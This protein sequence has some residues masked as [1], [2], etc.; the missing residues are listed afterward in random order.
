MCAACAPVVMGLVTLGGGKCVSLALAL[1][2]LAVL[3]AEVFPESLSLEMYPITMEAS[4]TTSQ[5]KPL[6]EIS[7]QRNLHV[8][9]A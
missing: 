4:T 1:A 8:R 2:F 6:F 3:E 5:F 9:P 7:K